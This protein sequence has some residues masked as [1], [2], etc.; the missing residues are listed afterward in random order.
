MATFK[1]KTLTNRKNAYI[2]SHNVLRFLAQSTK[3]KT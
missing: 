2:K 1:N 3:A